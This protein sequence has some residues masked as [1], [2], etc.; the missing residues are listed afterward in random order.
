MGRATPS[1]SA[2]PPPPP[3][4]AIHLYFDTLEVE[5]VFAFVE[6]VKVS[7]LGDCISSSTD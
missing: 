3:P 1:H 7:L 2:P 6:L 5:M 4:R